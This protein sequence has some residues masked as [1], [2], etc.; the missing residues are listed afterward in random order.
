[1]KVESWVILRGQKSESEPEF[2]S[3]IIPEKS[4]E[5][6]IR[7]KRKENESINVE[8]S[9]EVKVKVEIML[10]KQRNNKVKVKILQINPYNTEM[11][12]EVKVK[13]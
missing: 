9:Q 3:M 4:K 12:K 6:E 1:M 7:D 8:G 11:P 10:I 5:S 2:K 13:V